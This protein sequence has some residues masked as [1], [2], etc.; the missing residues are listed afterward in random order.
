MY[1]NEDRVVPS[2]CG[3]VQCLYS[4]VMYYKLVWFDIFRVFPCLRRSL[5]KTRNESG[6]KEAISKSN[7]LTKEKH[8]LQPLLAFTKPV[9]SFNSAWMNWWGQRAFVFC[10]VFLV[11]GGR[12]KVQISFSWILSKL[13]SYPFLKL[14]TVASNT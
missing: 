2:Q 8:S 13:I 3:M 6:S 12:H 11:F 10:Y 9:Q 5:G 7:A 14:P 4:C 1:Q